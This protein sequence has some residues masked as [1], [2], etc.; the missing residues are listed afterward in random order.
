MQG[1]K[2]IWMSVVHSKEK[3]FVFK[4]LNRYF[5]NLAVI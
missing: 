2:F 5:I 4:L 3:I 1:E